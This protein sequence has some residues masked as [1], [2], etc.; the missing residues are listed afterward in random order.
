MAP[1]R[2]RVRQPGPRTGPDAAPSSLREPVP[3]ALCPTPP[4]YPD[5]AS[6]GSERAWAGGCP[7]V[8]S[9][10]TAVVSHSRPIRTEAPTALG[11]P[12]PG[13]RPGPEALPGTAH[14]Q[15]L[16]NTGCKGPP[17]AAIWGDSKSQPSSRLSPGAGSSYGRAETVRPLLR[18]LPTGH[19]HA[20][21]Q[22]LETQPTAV[23]AY[24]KY[25]ASS[26]MSAGK[27]GLER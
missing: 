20:H 7:G 4:H 21:L 22:L 17:F 10:R 16:G 15:R 9:L 23:A 14:I 18:L 26:S 27:W 8:P 19:L 5:A 13:N 6:A 12:L 24:K 2:G 25:S 3:S 11:K 1:T